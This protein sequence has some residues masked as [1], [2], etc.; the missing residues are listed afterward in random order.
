MDSHFYGNDREESG[1]NKILSL[2]TA[3]GGK[4]IDF[5]PI[6]CSRSH[7]LN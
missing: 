6:N 1:N 5:K 4:I 2:I 3:R 7:Q